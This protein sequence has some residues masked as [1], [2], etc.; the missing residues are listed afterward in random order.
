MK[1]EYGKTIKESDCTITVGDTVVTTGIGAFRKGITMTITEVF[2]DRHNANYQYR[3]N[4]MILDQ[5]HIE[6]VEKIL[7]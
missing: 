4:G 3:A 7:S 1:C 2:L 6:K 5:W